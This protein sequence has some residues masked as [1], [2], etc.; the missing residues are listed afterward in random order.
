[1]ID[2]TDFPKTDRRLESIG[3]VYS[4]VAHKSILGIKALFLGITGGKTQM[5]LDFALFGEKGKNGNFGISQKEV[6]IR[7]SKERPED[8]PVQERMDEY[9]WSNISLIIAMINTAIKKKIKF[10]YIGRQ[11]VCLQWDY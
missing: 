1:M 9:T 8:C 6:D 10:R 5:L 7:F 2:D 11:L 3:R 4:H